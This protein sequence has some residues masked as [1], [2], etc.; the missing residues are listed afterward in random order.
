MN[1][2]LQTVLSGQYEFIAVKDVF[3]GMDELRRNEDIKLI[4]IDVDYS[5]QECW[6][7]IHHIN[8]SGLYQRPLIVLASEKVKKMDDQ[9]TD[10]YVNDYVYKP[11]NPPYLVRT[12]EKLLSMETT[13]NF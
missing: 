7:F 1:F 10:V 9:M 4:I 5:V 13:H 3:K 8:S 2:I 11:F 12:I 6:D